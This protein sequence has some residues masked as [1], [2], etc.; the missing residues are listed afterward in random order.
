[1]ARWSEGGWKNSSWKK[2]GGKKYITDRNGRSSWERRGIVAFCTCQWNE[3]VAVIMNVTIFWV[4]I[5]YILVEFYQRFAGTYV[6]YPESVGRMLCQTVRR[7]IPK[8]VTFIEGT[9]W[10]RDCGDGRKR[11]IRAGQIDSC[12]WERSRPAGIDRAPAIS[13]WCS[14]KLLLKLL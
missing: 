13:T 8:T 3:W 1:M 14:I 6:S 9:L 7:P 12:T 11:K 2:G 4:V 5:P 10:C